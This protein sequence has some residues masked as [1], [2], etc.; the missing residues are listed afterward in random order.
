MCEECEKRYEK[1]DYAWE[2]RLHAIPV[3][4]EYR[5]GI[6]LIASRT[7]NRPRRSRCRSVKSAGKRMVRIFFGQNS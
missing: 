5:H 6:P 1:D 2:H 4:Y 3:R 7:L